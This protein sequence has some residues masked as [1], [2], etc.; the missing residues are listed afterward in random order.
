MPDC[1]NPA[2]WDVAFSDDGTVSCSDYR[3]RFRFRGRGTIQIVW[4][5]GPQPG[6]NYSR[7]HN[8]ARQAC[9][10]ALGQRQR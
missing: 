7:L 4:E 3:G 6:P 2:G 5:K 8:A 1:L 9:Y 10:R